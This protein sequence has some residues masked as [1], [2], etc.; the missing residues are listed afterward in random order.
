MVYF[1]LASS[2]GHFQF[3]NVTRSFFGWRNSC[4]AQ[5]GMHSVWALQLLLV[6]D[7]YS[8]CYKKNMRVLPFVHV[9]VPRFAWKGTEVVSSPSPL[10][11][12]K[13]N[14]SDIHKSMDGYY[15]KECSL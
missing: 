14:I 11:S 6:F 12:K 8:V 15:G 2:P 7:S 13:R 4:K 1:G 10:L 3:F 9:C 5:I